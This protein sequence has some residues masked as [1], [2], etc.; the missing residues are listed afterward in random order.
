LIMDRYGIL[1]GKEAPRPLEADFKCDPANPFAWMEYQNSELAKRR[2][3]DFF[4]HVNKV[5]E[6]LDIL[7]SS[8][9]SAVPI[10]VRVTTE[11]NRANQNG[12]VFT[13][14]MRYKDGDI[15]INDKGEVARI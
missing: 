8:A 2:Y 7:G 11:K 14:Q 4:S 9:I 1:L 3:E 6:S 10:T 13:G 15:Y 12:D 5:A